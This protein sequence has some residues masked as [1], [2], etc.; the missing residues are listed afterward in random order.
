MHPEEKFEYLYFLCPGNFT[1]MQKSSVAPTVSK[2]K[3][4]DYESLELP[5][6]NQAFL[7]RALQH[8]LNARRAPA[9]RLHTSALIYH[10]D[11]YVIVIEYDQK[12]RDKASFVPMVL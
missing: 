2:E 9:V 12:H 11:S 10:I 4:A 1:V 7:P 8:P 3:S 5:M 6:E